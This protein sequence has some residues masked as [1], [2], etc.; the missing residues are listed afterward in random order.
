MKKKQQTHRT[1]KK[2]REKENK[3]FSINNLINEFKLRG[4]TI[5]LVSKYS[6][7]KPLNCTRNASNCIHTSILNTQTYIFWDCLKYRNMISSRYLY[8][9]MKSMDF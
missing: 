8:W 7:S 5:Q 9:F 1:K 4:F 6:L 3:N 2:E